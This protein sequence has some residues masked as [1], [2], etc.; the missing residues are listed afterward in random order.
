M[1]AVVRA[2]DILLLAQSRAPGD[3]E[4]LMIALADLCAQSDT[5]GL[6]DESIQA[7]MNTVFLHLVS[8]AERDIRKA[9]SQRLAEAPWA[10]YALVNVLALD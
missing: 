8:S 5:N 3:R 6:A 2:D 4:R 7:L 10:P 1:T 9:Q